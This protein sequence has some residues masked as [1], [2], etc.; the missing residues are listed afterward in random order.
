MDVEKDDATPGGPLNIYNE[1]A[2][3]VPETAHK[4]SSGTFLFNYSGFRIIYCLLIHLFIFDHVDSWFQAGF[5]LT[6]GINSAYVLGYSGAVM[7]PLG[8]V[9][10]VVG[11]ILATFISLYANILIAKL[12]E[13][14]GKRHIRYRD[15]AGFVY[16]PKAYSLTWVLQY[17]NLFMINVGY[18]MLSGQA[19][20]VGMIH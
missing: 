5:V 14:G 16:G 19:L 10:G 2:I 20:K 4:I 8:W 15:L 17:V 9:G 12:H 1:L 6:T 11:L 3:E 7:V 13:F 18:I